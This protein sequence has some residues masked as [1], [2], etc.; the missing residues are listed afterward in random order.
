MFVL[1]SW[2]LRGDYLKD[3]RYPRSVAYTYRQKQEW[4]F[5]SKNILTSYFPFSLSLIWICSNITLANS[6][7]IDIIKMCDHKFVLVL[8]KIFSFFQET[9]NQTVLWRLKHLGSPNKT[10]LWMSDW[11]LTRFTVCQS[12]LDESRDLGTSFPFL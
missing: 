1:G 6:V 11:R 3:C 10:Q 2:S 5:S 7:F 12:H 4:E 8:N 9:L